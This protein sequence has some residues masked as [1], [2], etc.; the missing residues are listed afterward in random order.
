MKFNGV[1]LKK[2]AV[3]DDEIARL[4]GL[5][6]LTTAELDGNHFLKHGVE[7]SLQIC[8]EV[9]VD[10]AQRI[11]AL[12]G[13]Q[14][15]ASAFDALLGLEAMGILASAERYRTMIQF[16]NF[17]V[18]RYERV[19][20]AVLVDIVRNRLGDLTSFRSEIAGAV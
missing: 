14:P 9:V 6:P 11:L 19:D 4:Q 16:R 10:V 5:G 15:A 1:V 13:R 17:V 12:Q 2:F 7:R 3:L 8:V 18:H 20:S